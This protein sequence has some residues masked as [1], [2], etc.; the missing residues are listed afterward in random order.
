MTKL[1]RFVEDRENTWAAL[2]RMVALRQKRGDRLSEDELRWLTR[3]YR[4]TAADL[5]TARRSFPA[6]PLVG[7]LEG[8]VRQAYSLINQDGASLNE[9]DTTD[10]GAWVGWKE[11]CSRRY[12][13]LVAGRPMLLA[14]SAVLLFLPMA[15]IILWA[16][17]DPDKVSGFIPSQFRDGSDEATDMGMSGG[18]QTAFASTI[19]TNNIRVSFL[20]FAAGIT[21]GLGTGYLLIVNGILIGAVLGMAVHYG[22]AANIA[23][24]ILPHGVLELSIIVVAAAT[25][26]RIGWGI[27]DPGTEA[28]SVVLIRESRAAMMVIAG[29]VPWFVLAGLIEG[30]VTPAGFGLVPAAI[31][32]CG[33]GA[34]YWGLVIWRGRKSIS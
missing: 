13:Q 20:V 15:L 10:I 6:S 25:G 11:F 2:G 22:N 31:V 24:L 32:G 30:Y 33:V 34:I 8:L 1:D 23:A 5:A 17:N 21:A 3:A 29:T 18:E 28:R 4:T 27:V 14:I 19:F 12:W 26:L 9:T 7:R 16:Q